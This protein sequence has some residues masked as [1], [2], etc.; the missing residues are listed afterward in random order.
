MKRSLWVLGG[1]LPVVLLLALLSV[2]VKFYLL[3]PATY[4]D[5]RVQY[6]ASTATPVIA[7]LNRYRSQ[8]STFPVAASQLASSLPRMHR[9][10]S[11]LAHDYVCGWHYEKRFDGRGYH[12]WRSLGW[13]PVLRYDY[14]GTT[15]RWVF[16]PGNG[17]PAQP[18][19][20]KP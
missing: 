13:D 9:A 8:H 12:I 2:F 17:S 15:G 20:P 10:H 14:D 18:F 6:E 16:N 19:I 11:D 4:T 1:C 3:D 5:P 7:A